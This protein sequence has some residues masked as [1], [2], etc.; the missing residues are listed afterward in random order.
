MLSPISIAAVARYHLK[1]YGQALKDV[2]MCEKLGVRP[3]ADFLK[4]LNQA[5]GRKE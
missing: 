5:A 1:E 4:S 3:P 2:R